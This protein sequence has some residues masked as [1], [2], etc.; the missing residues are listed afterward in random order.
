MAKLPDQTI[1][2]ILNLQR[3]LLEQMDRATAAV[4]AILEQYGETEETIPELDEL[5][6]LRERADSYYTRFYV[7][8]RRI[9]EAQPVALHD[10]LELLAKYINEADSTIAAIQASIQEIERN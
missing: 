7:T 9:Y 6:S 3:Q 1:T 2:D 8:L 10:S 4:F 5:Q